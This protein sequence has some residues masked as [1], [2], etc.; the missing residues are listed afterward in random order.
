MHRCPPAP[1]SDMGTYIPVL[2]YLSVPL[3]SK[4]NGSFLKESSY[5]K[6][7]QEH[8][9]PARISLSPLDCSAPDRLFCAAL[10]DFMRFS[11]EALFQTLRIQKNMKHVS[12]ESDKSRFK[13]LSL[14][15]LAQHFLCQGRV[16]Q[17]ICSKAE[18]FGHQT[19]TGYFLQHGL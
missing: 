17:A 7:K 2:L 10:V 6:T 11:D 12:G 1:A 9:G 16:S 14:M 13:L 19:I 18:H 15:Y 5:I 3:R 8:Y 4:Q